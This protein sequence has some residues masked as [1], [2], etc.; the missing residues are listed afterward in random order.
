MNDDV[1][2]FGGGGGGDTEIALG[3]CAP[4]KPI[5]ITTHAIRIHT[6]VTPVPIW[7]CRLPPCSAYNGA[8]SL[9]PSQCRIGHH[10]SLSFA[11]HSVRGLGP[12]LWWNA[13]RQGAC[14]S[15]LTLQYC[16]RVSFAHGVMAGQAAVV[17]MEKKR[18]LILIIH[19]FPALHRV[20]FAT[21]ELFSYSFL[22]TIYLPT[23]PTLLSLIVFLVLNQVFQNAFVSHFNCSFSVHVISYPFYTCNPSSLILVFHN[24]TTLQPLRSVQS[25]TPVHC[26]AH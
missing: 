14:L 17:T 26:S 15:H 24:I 22:V 7:C 3:A 8:P 19:S 1:G 13:L 4:S 16:L 25:K 18:P 2:E 6:L 23:L 11:S 21:L 12:G 9:S 10:L 20:F 5:P